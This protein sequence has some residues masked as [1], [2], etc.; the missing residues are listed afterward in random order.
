MRRNKTKSGWF[1][2][3]I[4]SDLWQSLGTRTGKRP[5]RK[6][7]RARKPSLEVLED[8]TLPS[9]T[10][11]IL[12]IDSRANPSVAVELRLDPGQSW[13]MTSPGV[14][15]SPAS[16]DVRIGLQ[17]KSG[18]F[19]SILE[20]SDVAVD[21]PLRAFVILTTPQT[22]NSLYY[23]P[24]GNT[25]FTANLFQFTQDYYFY[26]D[27]LTSDTGQTVTG[28]AL[29]QKA[30][31]GLDIGI[32]R[33]RPTSIQLTTTT[34]TDQ[35]PVL[36]LGGRVS[37]P[38][39][40]GAGPQA[41]SGLNLDL[42]SAATYGVTADA[43][44][45]VNIVASNGATGAM[46]RWTGEKT[47][48]IG[49]LVATVENAQ[50]GIDTTNKTLY[51]S[52]QISV[53]L[54][55]DS[56]TTATPWQLSLGT[57]DDPGLVISY[58]NNTPKLERLEAALIPGTQ[59][60]SSSSRAELSVAGMKL[61]I[62]GL[63]VLYD[64]NKSQIGIGGKATL[65]FG[66]GTA[67]SPAD[68]VTVYLGD[69]SRFEAGVLLGTDGSLLS[70][71]G[72]VFGNFKIF[73]AG[74]L[75][76]SNMEIDYDSKT[77]T[78]AFSGAALL[79][80]GSSLSVATTIDEAAPLK[81]VNG[82]WQI[83]SLASEINGSFSVFGFEIQPRNL[84]LGYSLRK[85]SSG[86]VDEVWTLKGG[87]S[88]PK[89]WNATLA[90]NAPGG[91][92]GLTITNG[93]W[94]L[95]GLQFSLDD[96]SIG[97]GIGLKGLTV[98]FQRT[99]DKSSWSLQLAGKVVLPGG[100]V[101]GASF[102]LQDGTPV[103]LGVSYA[104][105]GLSPGIPV[106]GTGL[107]ITAIGFDIHNLTSQDIVVQG[108]VGV[109]YGPALPASEG[110]L[111]GKRF[112]HADGTFKADRNEFDITSA[113]FKVAEGYY[114]QGTGSV[115]LNW[116]KHQY[117]ISVDL[118]LAAGVFEVKGE[119]TLNQFSQ[120]TFSAEVSLL[121]PNWVPFIGGSRLVSLDG[122]F[123]WDPVDPAQS[124]VAAWLDI[125]IFNIIHLR[126]G[127]EYDFQAGSIHWIGDSDIQQLQQLATVNRL[128]YSIDF[129]AAKLDHV[130]NQA[131]YEVQWDTPNQ[132]GSVAIQVPGQPEIDLAMGDYSVQTFK[133]ADGSV[134]DVAAVQ[135]LTGPNRYEIAIAA[136][137]RNPFADLPTGDYKF[138]VVSAE[139]LDAG[140]L[141]AAYSTMPPV[142]TNV[143]L[144]QPA[145]SNQVAV[146]LTYGT[147]D[148]QNTTIN[149]YYATDPGGSTGTRFASINLA[150]QPASGTVS[151]VWDLGQAAADPGA[152]GADVSP[153]ASDRN[154][155]V[156][157]TISD[158]TN[159]VGTS[160]VSTS[161]VA[162]QP[163]LRVNVNVIPD[164]PDGQPRS[165]LADWP[166][167][168][169]EVDARG[170]PVTAP[171]GQ[172]NLVAR[173][174]STITDDSGQSAIY[175]QPGTYWR[176]T[177]APFNPEGFSPVTPAG[178][179]PPPNSQ[180]VFNAVQ[181]GTAGKPTVLEADYQNSVSVSGLVSLDP[182]GTGETEE[183]GTGQ[184]GQI[185]YLDLNDNGKL[186]A[187]EPY[188]MT[189]LG[190][191]Y[192]LR[193]PLPS[194]TTN[195][196]IR[197]L[198]PAGTSTFV[199][200]N[201]DWT[202]AFTFTDG[203]SY[204]VAV[205]PAA[206]H[207]QSFGQR[208]FLEAR[209]YVV[210]GVAYVGGTSGGYEPGVQPA[211]G[212][213]IQIQSLD[214][215]NPYQ[216][217]TTTAADGSYSF[218]VPTAG[219]YQVS[220]TAAAGM[221][222]APAHNLFG[223]DAAPNALGLA[224]SVTTPQGAPLYSLGAAGSQPFTVSGD[225]FGNGLSDVA[226]LAV[227]SN[228]WSGSKT[229]NLYLAIV[230]GAASR[231]QVTTQV[232]LVA[233][234]VP[235]YAAQVPSL[236]WSDA[237]GVFVL[238]APTAR[239]STAASVYDP[240]TARLSPVPVPTG[241]A[242]L[243][244]LLA[245]SSSKAAGGDTWL[246]TSA[247]GS[248]WSLL[249]YT[250]YS[251][252]PVVLASYTFGSSNGGTLPY[253]S[254]GLQPVA[255]AGGRWAALAQGDFDGDGIPDYAF[256]AVTPGGT[257]VVAY[258]LS[259]EKYGKIHI[260]TPTAAQNSSTLASVEAVAQ[261]TAGGLSDLVVRLSG[262]GGNQVVVLTPTT[263][264][265]AST[266]FS[267]GSVFAPQGLLTNDLV[268]DVNG[269]GLPDL[270]L[271]GP[272]TLAVL[273]NRGG[274]AFA[275]PVYA[276]DPVQA[277][278]ISG[279]SPG[280]LGDGSTVAG[281]RTPGFL[282]L[283]SSAGGPLS[284]QLL[285]NTSQ[286]SN[287]YQV[288]LLSPGAYAGY[289]FGYVSARPTTSK[290]VGGF[291][292]LDANDA[293]TITPGDP[294][295]PGQQINITL[296]D[297]TVQTVTTNA[298]GHY[299]F[300]PTA[301]STFSAAGFAPLN[302]APAT[303]GG[304]Y[305][306]GTKPAEGT[307][308]D[309]GVSYPASDT[310][311]IQGVIVSDDSGTGVWAPTDRGLAGVTVFL[312][313]NGNGQPDPLE[314]QTVTDADGAYRF[315]GL[316]PGLYAVAQVVP[317]GSRQVTPAPDAPPRQVIAGQITYAVNFVDTVPSLSN[318]F[319]PNN[320][321]DIVNVG[322]GSYTT[323]FPD[324]STNPEYTSPTAKDYHP[325][326][327]V[328]L[329]DSSPSLTFPYVTPGSPYLDNP[330]PD[331]N[332]PLTTSEWWSSLLFRRNPDTPF[333]SMDPG[334]FS[335]LP[336]ANG[337]GLAYV[338]TPVVQNVPA[339]DPR[340]AGTQ[341]YQYQYPQYQDGNGNFD[342]VYKSDL[343]VGLRELTS[344]DPGKV[345][346]YNYSDWTVTADWNSQ[347][348][349]TAGEGLPYLY[350]Q[351]PEGG[352][353]TVTFGD[354]QHVSLVPGFSG[355]LLVKVD[356]LGMDN[357]YH[358]NYY[359]IFGPPGADAW[360]TSNPAQYVLNVLTSANGYLSVAIM[361]DGFDPGT[362]DGRQT[363]ELFREHAYNFVT[364]ARAT[365]TFTEANGQVVTQ[366]ALATTFMAAGSGDSTLNTTS[367]LQALYPTQWLY[368]S[369]GSADAAHSYASPR[370]PMRLLT[371]NEFA[372]TLQYQG[373]LPYVP[374]VPDSGDTTGYHDALWN[375]VLLP[376]LRTRS[377]ND[378]A[379]HSNDSNLNL[380]NLLRGDDVYSQGQSMLGAA[381][382]IPLLNQ[383]AQDL[384]A[385]SNPTWRAEGALA[386]RYAQEV[387]DAV[388]DDI[389]AWLSADDD[390]KI[391]FFYYDQNFD[392]LLAAPGAY[393]SSDSVNDQ[394]LGLGY[395]I[396]TAAILAEYDPGWA[397]TS[398]MGGMIDLLVKEV[399][400]PDR[401]TDGQQT[402]LPYL[403]NF[404]PYAGHSWADGAANSA[405][406]NNQESSSEAI[407]FASGLI[408][409]GEATNDPQLRDTGVYLYT[410]EVTS[411]NYYY[412]N[413][414]N[415]QN[416]AAQPG[417]TRPQISILE[418]IGGEYQTF[419]GTQPEI[420]TA[421]QFLPFTGSSYYLANV[422]S[423]KNASGQP[424]TD[425]TY[426]AQEL[427]A[428][429]VGDQTVYQN[430]LCMFSALQGQAQAQ[431]ALAYLFNPDGSPKFL[432]FD[433]AR[434]T[435]YSANNGV[436]NPAFDYNWLSVLAAYGRPDFSVTADTTSYAVFVS[437]AGAR[438]YVAYNPT[439]DPL[440]VTFSDGFVL[441]VPA[442]STKTSAGLTS[443]A[444]AG[445]G[446]STT[447]PDYSLKT[448]PS[449]LFLVSGDPSQPGQGTFLIGAT[450]GG[451]TTMQVP[452]ANN[453]ATDAGLT[454][455]LP[456]DA[457][458][459]T[460][461]I[462]G[463]NGSLDATKVQ[464][465]TPV[466]FS[467]WLD[468]GVIPNTVN[469]SQVGFLFEVYNNGGTRPTYSAR[470]TP[471]VPPSSSDTGVVTGFTT[472]YT[473]AVL[474]GVEDTS[475]KLPATLTDATIR[476]T[477]FNELGLT[478]VAV[479]VDAAAEQG[480][481]SYVDLPYDVTVTG[482]V[483]VTL[484]ADK[485][486]VTQGTSL[487]ITATV[488][489][490]GKTAPSGQVVF[491]NGGQQIGDPL[492]L[493]Q[494]T[495]A[496]GFSSS[497]AVLVGYTGLPVGT[498]ELSAR[499]YG[500][501]AVTGVSVT[502][503]GTGQIVRING[504]NLDNA[505]E[506]TFGGADALSFT[507][508]S[509]NQITAVVGSKGTGPVAVTTLGGVA[510]APGTFTYLTSPAPTI[511]GYSP[512]AA[513]PGAALTITGTNLTGATAVT[514]GGQP[515]KFTVNSGGTQIMATLGSGT[516]ASGPIEVAT[517]GGTAS[518]AYLSGA[519]ISSPENPDKRSFS[520]GGGGPNI[521]GLS[522][523][524]GGAGGQLL[525][526]G[527]S[528]DGTTAVTV[529]GQSEPFTLDSSTQITVTLDAKAATGAVKVRTPRGAATSWQIFT[530]ATGTAPALASPVVPV[531]VSEPESSKAK[532]SVTVSSSAPTVTYGSTAQP[533]IF[534][535]AVFS[536]SGVPTGGVTFRL[537]DDVLATVPLSAAGT[538]TYIP[539]KPLL[540]GV[541]QLRAEYTGDPA[542]AATASPPVTQTVTKANALL[543]SVDAV[544]S[545]AVYGSVILRATLR[546]EGASQ[547]VFPAGSIDFYDGTTFL[548]HGGTTF[549]PG[550][551]T[552]TTPAAGRPGA[553]EPGVHN[554]RAVYAGDAYYQPVASPAQGFALT[555][556]PKDQTQGHATTTTVTA[557]VNDTTTPKFL[558]NQPAFFN[559][560]VAVSGAGPDFVGFPTGQ[561]TLQYQYQGIN[562]N[563]PEATWHDVDVNPSFLLL[564]YT[565]QPNLNQT[566][567]DQLPSF[568]PTMPGYYQ[569]RAVYQSRIDFGTNPNPQF[570]DS[571]SAPLTVQVVPPDNTTAE[572]L[573]PTR[574]ALTAAQS[575][576]LPADTTLLG[577]SLVL[578]ARVTSPNSWTSG[579][580]TGA[581]TGPDGRIGFVQFF[582]GGKAYGG[583]IPVSPTGVA[584][585]I[586]PALPP[587]TSSWTAQFQH[588]IN[589]TLFENSMSNPTQKAIPHTVQASDP[590]QLSVVV[591]S[592]AN[593]ATA[594][595][596][597]T[598]T[599]AVTG[600][601]ARGVGAPGGRVQ[602]QI[603]KDGVD[604]GGFVM[605]DGQ[606]R[607]AFQTSRLVAG[608]YTVTA[609]YNVDRGDPYF[610]S[611]TPQNTSVPF[612][613]TVNAPGLALR[614][615]LLPTARTAE[616]TP[617]VLSR[618]N[619]DADVVT[620]DGAP[621]DTLLSVSMAAR[622]ATIAL[623][624]TAGLHFIQGGGL[625]A[626][627]MTFSGTLAEI[628]SAFDGLRLTPQAGFVGDAT[629]DITVS[630]PE[631]PGEPDTGPA[632]DSE[633]LD[634]TVA[635]PAP[636]LSRL[637][638][639][640][641][642]G[643]TIHPGNLVTL[644]GTVVAAAAA[645]ADT[646]RVN[647][648]DGSTPTVLALTPGASSF[649]LTHVFAA[650]G[651][652]G[653][654]YVVTATI[655]D[656][657]GGSATS[658]VKV[659]VVPVPPRVCLVEE[660]HQAV[661]HRDAWLSLLLA[662]AR[663]EGMI[664]ALL[665][666]AEHHR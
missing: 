139:K 51:F 429:T 517:P 492:R 453:G 150:G 387:F 558:L 652:A 167:T 230:K 472:P 166:V 501:P 241:V 335:L 190:G 494:P 391:R 474:G 204:T 343:T 497:Q 630:A 169:E 297:G 188:T 101:L 572:G 2:P 189:D 245:V 59:D 302:T 374:D 443:A 644:T 334:P 336:S 312:D 547:G 48:N 288:K 448:A 333:Y 587:G 197:L 570:L 56:D 26:V 282:F 437:D 123:Y 656:P 568:T 253:L 409:W 456:P 442:H 457:P 383:V 137:A 91:N 203:D 199:R 600:Q 99:A 117:D 16:Q 68:S 463:V 621:A 72:S 554:I 37:I 40:G 345:T 15:T 321:P 648:G 350:Y 147:A 634:V 116:G 134:F 445:Q 370:G 128:G 509:P 657:F 418:G 25:A 237:L 5:V 339:G 653:R 596:E 631:S 564:Y 256:S 260:L 484:A 486:N 255:L 317:P 84:Q 598:F 49:P 342:G 308:Y 360:D 491:Y 337:L 613:L 422:G 355:G 174:V 223:T 88:L 214:P 23:L 292:F 81:W 520:I 516:S 273:V 186:D 58:A 63:Y 358:T 120:I 10:S 138:H 408:A 131:L 386:A 284:M 473:Q 604:Y 224:L 75:A 627:A 411:V 389:G 622:H 320:Q 265:G 274:G 215:Q 158:S 231:A 592:S 607:G 528:L 67:D 398:Q 401:D 314:P 625:G 479:R 178:Q 504:V 566:L 430:P 490:V 29:D 660:L 322:V 122:L 530:V 460:F 483:G 244:T 395:F 580:F 629:L 438:T 270:V 309:F 423:F 160:A 348:R 636:K 155:Y 431:Q 247:G 217:T 264:G 327:T 661:L 60:G 639:T 608:T 301:G 452:G 130:A 638:V 449:R 597:T 414:N 436:D 86:G 637:A 290:T 14:Y 193:F 227:D 619:H 397:A 177:V 161:A 579:P 617:L 257:T 352:T 259:G 78:V 110:F 200:A 402:P 536:G 141:S 427:Q 212:E 46:V 90:F 286:P 165:V 180:T 313:L 583:L 413:Q 593:P 361:P 614:S 385:S 426:I 93:Q 406:G 311:S 563:T 555:V 633:M 289:N 50:F 268:A 280:L 511:T 159:P 65:Q 6:A 441:D 359:A 464:P 500:A 24:N 378:K 104:A 127:L 30:D 462:A 196:T 434:G 82:N 642:G 535:A 390:D 294:T 519:G 662:A 502:Q 482:P 319:D 399:A 664:W 229:A 525:I 34:P 176:V 192:T 527:R 100:I 310:G 394:Q 226:T 540:P 650:P 628:D 267:V 353:P 589:T 577:E 419:F 382:L 8:R 654:P 149:L 477:L 407:N 272:S 281:K 299:S 7:P 468:G 187:D 66:Q 371:G 105:T 156:Y 515:T 428:A 218:T 603:V 151:P 326:S 182:Q 392:A 623:G 129:P 240:K 341:Y 362:A 201:I 234:N 404:D 283:G 384:S 133:T 372:T 239:G 340:G 19:V 620:D 557:M 102:K 52:G 42:T 266:Y 125:N 70:F 304:S 73:G 508:D 45:D 573:Y 213:T 470:F 635:P 162:L 31:Y 295:V 601:S 562:G 364:D 136:D 207:L 615:S 185:V 235:A 559:A 13:T 444:P 590:R 507:V 114:G 363:F 510:T 140:S 499:Y 467:I 97:G 626:S 33:L 80:V 354:P 300:T 415:P 9:S 191:A 512:G 575:P 146:N 439:A 198:P 377:T 357:Q 315:G 542:F 168:W 412:F 324:N 41:L 1:S 424:V 27:Q 53:A 582:K 651:P 495:N 3:T 209:A 179:Q 376:Y 552:F 126:G 206:P 269:D 480:R 526:T 279:G 388:K 521:D 420:V 35:S 163:N 233:Q 121:V 403:R 641:A 124:K 478:P 106:L 74:K 11:N 98:N 205:N 249:R 553:L 465:G 118:F 17:P 609:V 184:P 62:D 544:G 529:G 263:A 39:V 21:V 32:G 433:G 77:A 157:A 655:T 119:F 513:G 550:V 514:V 545:P 523:L 202:T 307:G 153:L 599:V 145:G 291:A 417:V 108:H 584:T 658:S 578:T 293:G 421:I 152:V 142:V 505:R 369:A 4:F 111:A 18:S 107:F 170:N 316:A 92:P 416:P 20:A 574:I 450:G 393:Y 458:A 461:T 83:D 454:A 262:P 645:G 665:T 632:A 455:L 643:A 306:V 605:L 61:G 666:P 246:M 171:D 538:A 606:G 243:T 466:D 175:A 379:D 242:G 524:V 220:P 595:D 649:H 103:D 323:D 498:D 303:P 571:T 112:F 400:N 488:T 531:T 36:H 373:T 476:V 561:V 611:K 380:A 164:Q 446:L 325:P 440:A 210:A 451:A 581:V 305:T 618:A 89:L 349:V 640:G 506:V 565:G 347:M 569:I 287:A 43:R 135:Q 616:G 109:A 28:T 54:K 338:S 576:G 222:T 659:A 425:P 518:S 534:T 410:T 624:S 251:K 663:D 447:T 522:S 560:A 646:V 610:P 277:Q 459:F 368:L 148:A 330:N 71:S 44:G 219:Q 211:A 12:D 435:P 64:P 375:E 144:D 172:G 549:E 594:L 22:D 261:G 585:L 539:D 586:I 252:P 248:T 143:S 57:R 332:K 533:L 232:V 351:F 405:N 69:P 271:A 551:L 254:D 173:T 276:A 76:I 115:T 432:P 344:T 548:G 496:N 396:K 285:D 475:G 356:Q 556:L 481:V 278:L 181:P 228:A 154:Y 236:F 366:L 602:V 194:T 216:N 346:V 591:T 546:P 365:P 87:V 132:I 588:N 96:I 543:V 55:G 489:A 250:D 541:Y 471:F 328:Q 94:D 208:D 275:A 532:P 113:T 485:N 503:G 331:L 85:N 329:P 567:L 469:S 221:V 612:T 238:A 537:G 79:S 38:G 195:Y 367:A 647:W 296:P 95:N 493:V 487:D 225:F 318:T 47:F 258:L 183:G 381:Q 298:A